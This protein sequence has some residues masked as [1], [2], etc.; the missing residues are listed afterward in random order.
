M[1]WNQ[2]EKRIRR[3]RLQRILRTL[4]QK[5]WAS[6][7]VKTIAQLHSRV[8]H[9]SDFTIMV[10]ATIF[11]ASVLHQPLESKDQIA[12][13]EAC[14]LLGNE[15]LRWLISWEHMHPLLLVTG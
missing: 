10:N 11:Q 7:E 9:D 5:T 12:K 4:L 6:E 1:I 14:Y 13:I 2:R 3:F 15:V 8:S